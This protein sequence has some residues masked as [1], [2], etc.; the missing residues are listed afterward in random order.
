MNVRI[1]GLHNMKTHGT[2]ARKGLLVSVARDW[3]KAGEQSGKAADS[4]F[5]DNWDV[6]RHIFKKE[7]SP[8]TVTRV[9]RRQEFDFERRAISQAISQ[10]I[11]RIAYLLGEFQRAIEEGTPVSLQV[12]EQLKSR[13]AELKKRGVV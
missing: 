1:R 9:S 11:E 5:A 8:N 2:L 6:Q 3:Y 13:L 12:F 10:Q 7:R 4:T